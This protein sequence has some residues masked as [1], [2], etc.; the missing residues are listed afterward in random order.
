MDSHICICAQK[1]ENCAEC[2]SHKMLI[3]ETRVLWQKLCRFTNLWK[4]H[5][6]CAAQ[7]HTM[8]TSDFRLEVEI[9]PF[10]ACTIKNMHSNPITYLAELCSSVSESASRG[11][12]R[13]TA[14]GVTW[15]YLAPEQWET[16]KSVSL[17]PDQ[18][19]GTHFL[20]QFV[21]HHWHWLSSVSVWKL[22]Y[23]AEHTKH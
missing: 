3:Q 20:W 5:I 4:L 13:S 2:F 6:N 23:S 10:R 9:W 14:R 1:L 17:F 15:Q 22:R 19:C 21:T 11:H 8:M 12:L 16:A 18:P 7:L